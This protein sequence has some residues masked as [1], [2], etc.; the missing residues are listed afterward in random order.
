MKKLLTVLFFLLTVSSFSQQ[1][2]ALVIGN[3]NY[4]GISNLK[5]PVNDA[6]DMEAAL[7]DLGFSVD[8]VIDGTLE[9]M[10]NSVL[11]FSRKLGISYNTYGFFFYAGHGVQSSGENYLIP[12]TA[13][14]IRSETQLRE[15]AVSLQF[16]LDS[17][18]DAG[19]E[20][21]MI[22][23]D[24]CRD[25]PFGWARG[26]SRGLSVL[27]NAPS[28]S[29]VMYATSANSTADDGTGRNGLFSGC[30]LNNIK[31]QGLSVYDIFDRTMENV[32]NITSGRQ[33]PE[34]SLRFPGASRTYLNSI[35]V[36]ITP[37]IALIPV[38]PK[39]TNLRAGIP[40]TDSV[41]IAW[42][43]AGPGITYKLYW[44]SQNDPANANILSNAIIETTININGLISGTNYYFWV[45][46]VQNDQE[47]QKSTEIFVKTAIPV[48]T[49]VVQP[50]AR[51]VRTIPDGYVIISGGTFLMGS[52]TKELNRNNNETQ[53]QVTVNSFIMGKYEVT[54]N[55][56]QEIMGGNSSIKDVFKGENLP[57]VYVNWINAINYCNKISERDG[58]T[59]VYNIK[60]SQTQ[61]WDVTWNHN[62]DG[63]RLPTEAEWEYACRA[64][65]VTPFNTG[66][67]I[68][69]DQANFN[70]TNPYNNN[71]KGE[72]RKILMPV[73]S[74][75]AN[76]F[77]LY[78]MH[79][80]VWEWCW[81]LFG[82]YSSGAQ[83]NPLGSTTGTTHVVR[84]GSWDRD[85]QSLRS[86]FR[87]F[88][89]VDYIGNNI[90][91][92]VVRSWE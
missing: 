22:V 27:S 88:Y 62:A 33:H 79:G 91:F 68:T 64:G 80:N 25:N 53:H 17:M 66:N 7:K 76:N 43:S 11:S 49:Q 69:S 6:N 42:D 41:T 46:S 70:A 14:N 59:P 34:L 10:E 30:L 75:P 51:S 65:T 21:N 87:Y 13:D 29:I 4:S 63:Y 84:G 12:V 78:D 83:N 89:D 36:D 40:G 54:Q 37:Q 38:P 5:N 18:G 60:I 72:F 61:K 2:F 57:I 82:N 35:P 39:P 47:S 28:G 8:K 19:N 58:L 23:L 74:F 3:G 44:S 92:R 48:I 20:L 90:G 67:N 15:R 73:G 45:T 16:I 77:G 86:A 31:T 26:G 85:A 81:D 32:I 1:K 71:P 52:S 56:Y 9:Q 55:E 24:A 50:P